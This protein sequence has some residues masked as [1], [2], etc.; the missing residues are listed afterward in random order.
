MVAEV[1]FVLAQVIPRVLLERP[2]TLTKRRNPQGRSTSV[3]AVHTVTPVATLNVAPIDSYINTSTHRPAH[4]FLR[5]PNLPGQYTY[6]M[7]T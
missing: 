6:E 3:M 5:D 7:D 4:S 1:A 2:Q